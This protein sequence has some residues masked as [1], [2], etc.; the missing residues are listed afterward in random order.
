M[1]IITLDDEMECKIKKM[2]EFQFSI[3][4]LFWKRWIVKDD[5]LFSLHTMWQQQVCISTTLQ[6]QACTYA[7][8]IETKHT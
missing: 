4:I 2:Y 6:Q 3:Y 8:T 5:W 7:T 1:K